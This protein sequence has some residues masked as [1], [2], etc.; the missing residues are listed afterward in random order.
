MTR[1]LRIGVVTM[2]RDES[3]LLSAWISYHRQLL[4]PQNVFVLDNLSSDPVT[5]EVLDRAR[6]DGITV[7]PANGLQDFELKGEIVSR[8]IAVHVEFDWIFPIDADEFL[9]VNMDGFQSSLDLISKELLSADDAGCSVVRVG[10]YVM[11]IPHS[12]RGFWANAQKIGVKPS[13]NISFGK[14]YHL[15]DY[16]TKLDVRGNF[17]IHPCSIAY[18]HFHNR[19][20]RELLVRARLK[21]SQRVPDFSPSTLAA[22]DGDG[23]FVARYFEITECDYLDRFPAGDVQLGPVFS[24]FGLQVP[25]SA[26]RQAIDER[27]L[28]RLH[29]PVNLHR[30]Q[31]VVRA[32]P[33]EVSALLDLMDKAVCYLEYGIGGSTLMAL[34]AGVQSVT[35]V[36]SDLEYI[37]HAINAYALRK[38][39]DGSRLKVKHVYMGETKKWGYPRFAPEARQ[40]EEYL[41]Q[42]ELGSPFDLVFI[43]GRYRVAIAAAAYR[44]A[45]LET[46]IAIHDYRSRPHYHQ[47]EAFL[48]LQYEVGDLAVF[49]AAPDRSSVAEAVRAQ[50]L[51]DPR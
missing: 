46:V 32:S 20:F 34:T 50:Y 26:P 15:F 7:L 11:N 18:L 12:E 42:A 48:T 28:K 1:Q 10:R 17:D 41:S 38:F 14:G 19:P 29:H 25:F 6:E 24:Q 4:G 16:S 43:D 9:G 21:L 33:D 37:E 23:R 51:N 22:Y 47:V 36:E 45:S 3:H 5:V 40:I 44:H 27:E 30:M 31:S 8:F 39:I 49:R 35:S 2:Q 13:G